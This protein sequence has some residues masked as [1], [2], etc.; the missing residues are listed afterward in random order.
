MADALVRTGDYEQSVIHHILYC[1]PFGYRIHLEVHSGHRIEYPRASPPLGNRLDYQRLA[2]DRASVPGLALTGLRGL[3]QVLAQPSSET[4]EL[5][6]LQLAQLGVAECPSPEADLDL[7]FEVPRLVQRQR[8][9]HDN[10]ERVEPA[11]ACGARVHPGRYPA[12][13]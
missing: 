5:G 1:S 7:G 12:V 4:V 8:F 11:I 9:Q 3:L 2:P 6:M 13:R 10:P